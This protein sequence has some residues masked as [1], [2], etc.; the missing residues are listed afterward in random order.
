MTSV[1]RR[2]RDTV[3]ATLIAVFATALVVRLI[4]LWQIRDSVYLSVLIGDAR[5]Y[6]AWARQI[7]A[8][9]WLGSDVFYQAP[10][11]P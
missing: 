1:P 4:Y 3:A 8:G 9:D 10:L 2:D 5:V 11:Y 7:A 6:D